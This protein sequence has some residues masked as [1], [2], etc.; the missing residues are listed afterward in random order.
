MTSNLIKSFFEILD[1]CI[2]ISLVCSSIMLFI[3][4]R[5]LYI[6]SS[7]IWFRKRG[8]ILLWSYL[9]ASGIATILI[10][11]LII[12]VDTLTQ[13]STLGFNINFTKDD[14]TLTILTRIKNIL[15][16]IWFFSALFVQTIL[17]IRI[18]LQFVNVRRAQTS[19]DWKHCIDPN[20]EIK[21]SWILK[22]YYIL[23]NPNY[24]FVI[25]ISYWMVEVIA[26]LIVVYANNGT[27]LTFPDRFGIFLITVSLFCNIQYCFAVYFVWNLRKCIDFDGL[28]IWKEF[29]I[30]F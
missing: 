14:T 6:N 19:D 20:Y 23:G 17:V 30:L 28:F 26:G 25:N 21:F 7:Q 22:Y 13:P 27:F 15:L 18:I 4:A 2:A 8:L 3:A 1:D 12:C 10:P 11:P 24:L 5:C 29:K 16:F 9:I